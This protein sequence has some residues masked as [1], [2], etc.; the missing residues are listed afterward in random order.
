[1]AE[2]TG[3]GK[4]CVHCGS[5][6]AQRIGYCDECGQA[7]CDRCGN[8]QIAL[9]TCKVMHDSCLKQCSDSAFSMIKFVKK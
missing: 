7:V 8:T 9:G 3:N 5:I 2:P 6:G 4:M 1:M